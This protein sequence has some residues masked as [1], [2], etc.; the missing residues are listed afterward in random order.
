MLKSSRSGAFPPQESRKGRNS[1]KQFK[2]QRKV[3][4]LITKVFPREPDNASVH[5]KNLQE[6]RP[7]FTKS[8]P[9]YRFFADFDG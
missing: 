4:S 2:K 9:L 7:I 8:V 1:R 3:I 5:G 6:K